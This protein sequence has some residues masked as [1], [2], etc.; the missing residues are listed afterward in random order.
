VPFH[1]RIRALLL[2][3]VLVSPTAQALLAE[4]TA[5]LSSSLPNFADDGLGLGT[6]F[7]TWPFQCTIK[8]LPLG[9]SPTAHALLAEV[10]ATPNSWPL[11]VNEPAGASDPARAAAAVAGVAPPATPARSS[12]TADSLTERVM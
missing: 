10:A 7:N 11:M 1:R 6:C 8:V 3:L 12:G 2:V 9:V 4:V 5:T